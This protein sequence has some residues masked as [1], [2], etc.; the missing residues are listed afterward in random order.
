MPRA[1]ADPIVASLLYGIYSGCLVRDDASDST[2][3]PSDA[4][5]PQPV[6]HSREDQQHR[7]HEERRLEEWL[8]KELCH[9]RARPQKK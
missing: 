9:A 2:I 7:K 3:T 5:A 6:Q 8:R 4:D 1:G